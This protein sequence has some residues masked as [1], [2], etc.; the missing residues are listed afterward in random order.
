MALDGFVLTN[1]GAELLSQAALTGDIVFTRGAVGSGAMSAT[2]DLALRTALIMPVADMQIGQV[3]RDGDKICVLCRFTNLKS[4]G[5]YLSAFRWNEAGLFARLGE[6]GDE[7]MLA[8]ANTRDVTAGDLI[9]ATAC[10]FELSVEL[11]FT[12]MDEVEFSAEGIMYVTW[13][14]L[15]EELATKAAAQHTHAASDVTTGTLAGRVLANAMAANSL[16]VKQVRNIAIS[17][18]APSNASNGDVWLS[19]TQ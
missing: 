8:Y 19:Y 11:A 1:A 15:S 3:V 6:A 13:P 5:S 7:V 17:T 16:A 14:E 18:T 12:G 10:E 2:G 9:P 4:D